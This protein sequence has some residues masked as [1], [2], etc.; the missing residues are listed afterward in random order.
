VNAG[1]FGFSDNQIFLQ[2]MNNLYPQDPH[3]NGLVRTVVSDRNGTLLM[4]MNTANEVR[5]VAIENSSTYA[6]DTWPHFMVSQDFKKLIDLATFSQVLLSLN[7]Q[8]W[9]VN[10]IANP[11][12][13]SYFSDATYNITFLLRRKDNP[14]VVLFLRYTP[15]SIHTDTNSPPEYDESF[16]GEQWGQASY[17]GAVADLGGPLSPDGSARNITIDLGELLN[18]AIVKAQNSSPPVSLSSLADY[19]L[20]GVGFGWETMGYEEVESQIS[21]L[22]FY[23]S[24]KMIFDSEVYQDS[25]YQAYNGDLP[26]SGDWAAGQRRAHWV[27][28]GCHEGRAA[29]TTFDVKI[30][31]ERSAIP[32]RGTA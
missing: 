23:G 14:Y 6:L 22:S 18:K 25:V 9:P 2:N 29:S 26:W 19:Y 20:A 32:Q 10:I 11:I 17:R 15:Y 16:G 13:G 24:P 12:P 21:S 7:V 5:N 4:Y 27:E 30:Y 28:Y 1:L 3:Y 31:M 8:V